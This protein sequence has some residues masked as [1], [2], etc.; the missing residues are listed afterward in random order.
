M[1]VVGSFWI[2]VMLYGLLALLAV[3]L[4]RII[5]WASHIKLDFIHQNYPLSKLVILGI[6]SLV[7]TAILVAGYH[8]AHHPKVTHVEVKVE[9]KVG[10]LSSLRVV[11]ASDIHL[12][13]TTGQKSLARM[14][15]VMNEQRP[16]LVLLAGDTFDGSPAHIIKKD[17]CVEFDRL[18]TKYGAY[19]VSGNHEYI[20]ERE[21]PNSV[22]IAFDY[23]SSHG[24]QPLQDTVILVDSSFYLAGRKD[25]MDR[26]R[27]TLP[28]LLNGIDRQL[29]VIMLDHQPF[30]LD[31]AEQAGIDLHLSG[32][33]HHGQMWPLNY[34]TRKI[35]EQDW[36]FF[37]LVLSK[38]YVSCGGGTWGASVRTAGYSEIVVIDLSF[39]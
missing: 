6:F 17:I 10:Q 7:I 8:R 11:M 28:E 21:T 37:L 23:I 13:Q 15:D 36:G 4:L 24:V 9:K 19:A 12:G 34:I 5:G 16:D 3:D 29:P 27:K 20:G 38:F 39:L 30:Q 18:Q 26:N 32:H 2:A 22:N 14:I 35:Y 31:E 25:R 33:T 1:F